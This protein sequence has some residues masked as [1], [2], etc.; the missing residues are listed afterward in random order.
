MHAYSA[1]GDTILKQN[2][3]QKN[4]WVSNLYNITVGYI[5]TNLRTEY[6]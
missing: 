4:L 5:I 3:V 2:S 1:S 6:K